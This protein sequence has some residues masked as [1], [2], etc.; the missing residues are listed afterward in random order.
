MTALW[1]WIINFTAFYSINFVYL[2]AS[3]VENI[4]SGVIFNRFN[5]GF[6]ILPECSTVKNC[7]WSNK[8]IYSWVPCACQQAPGSP[9]LTCRPCKWHRNVARRPEHSTENKQWPGLPCQWRR[10]THGPIASAAHHPNRP[11]MGEAWCGQQWQRQTRRRCASD[12]RQGAL[13]RSSRVIVSVIVRFTFG[14]GKQLLLHVFQVT[15]LC[16]H[17][18]VLLSEYPSW[19]R[20]EQKWLI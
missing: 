8:D 4:S 6:L 11:L 16:T 5:V 19:I 1:H 7:V 14:L 2:A 3:R 15:H 17:S 20:L 10:A 12:R 9:S 13:H 18:S